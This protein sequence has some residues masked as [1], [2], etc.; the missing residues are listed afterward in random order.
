MFS[1]LFSHCGVKG[2][3]FGVFPVILTEYTGEIK[4]PESAEISLEKAI[5]RGFYGAGSRTRTGDLLI[6]NQLLYQLSYPGARGGLKI[7]L[8]PLDVNILLD[9]YGFFVATEPCSLF[10][11]P[12]KA[13]FFNVSASEKYFS[14][15]F[16]H[17]SSD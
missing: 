8:S 5:F 16:L 2:G 7:N 11:F 6:T 3:Y 4:N 13:F 1:H 17:D 14:K 9:L 12:A 10:F 15:A